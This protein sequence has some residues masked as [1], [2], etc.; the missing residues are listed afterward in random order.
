MHG[1]GFAR[2]LSGRT[3]MQPSTAVQF[4]NG[5]AQTVLGPCEI[6]YACH[7]S[8]GSTP[9]GLQLLR[10]QVLTSGG[11]TCLRPVHGPK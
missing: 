10:L 9:V 7:E 5:Q 11:G 3:S 4:G 2:N 8:T 6:R 1:T